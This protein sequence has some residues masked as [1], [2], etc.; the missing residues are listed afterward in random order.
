M[1]FSGSLSSAIHPGFRTFFSLVT[2]RHP[3]LPAQNCLA[4][5][6]RV[7]WPENPTEPRWPHSPG[8]FGFC[9]TD[10]YP[11]RIIPVILTPH[12]LV[13]P[14][15]FLHVHYCQPR[16]SCRHLFPRLLPSL[17]WLVE[18]WLPARPQNACSVAGETWNTADPNMWFPCLK[19]TSKA[20]FPLL[21][22]Q[23][24]GYGLPRPCLDWDFQTLQPP[25]HRLWS[26]C[27]STARRTVNMPEYL[28]GRS[29]KHLL[30][31]STFSFPTLC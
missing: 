8:L 12:Y 24:S 29:M 14:S 26:H 20:A 28:L 23:N 21:L 15:S 31:I 22:R 19:K 17:L 11:E 25:L 16:S 6:P 2:T 30:P 13:N 1:S 18:L 5:G 27:I 4:A 10:C 3:L 7:V 9:F